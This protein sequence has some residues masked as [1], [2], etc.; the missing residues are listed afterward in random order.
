MKKTKKLLAILLAGIMLFAMFSISA[1]AKEMT[2]SEVVKFYHSVLKKTAEKNK[3]VLAKNTWKMRDSV[4]LSGLSG[5]D[6]M[7]TER[8]YET[9]DG[10]WYEESIDLYL[11]GVNGE[12]E[13]ATDTEIYDW[14]N[15]AND[16]DYNYT[17]KSAKYADNKITIVLE[18]DDEYWYQTKKVTVNLNSSNVIKKITIET[19][20]KYEEYSSLKQTPFYVESELSDV[21]TFTYDKIPAKKL[22]L[23]ET[24]ITLGY[25][26]T[27]ELTYTIGP[28][29]ASFNGVYVE[30]ESWD[31][32]GEDW[33]DAVLAYEEDGKIIIEAIE[34]GAATVSVYTYSGDVLATCEVTV[35]YSAW[36]RI[37]A[38]FDEIFYWFEMLFPFYY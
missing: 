15:I 14:F 32:M 26:D 23:S 3:V 5:L 37:V 4:D 9:Y 8:D 10:E 21:Y 2:K 16:L 1:G 31:D 24:N 28:D 34:E 35:E 33:Y 17:L 38:I 7:L 19:Y 30:V 22:T 13:E 18:S 12:Y 27:A 20:D 11:Y 25:N 36:D 6:L 29:N